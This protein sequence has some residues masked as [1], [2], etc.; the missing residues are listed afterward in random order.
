MQAR[1]GRHVVADQKKAATQLS[2]QEK[3]HALELKSMQK[4]IDDRDKVIEASSHCYK[5]IH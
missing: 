5:L 4:E 1:H 2:Q 3:L